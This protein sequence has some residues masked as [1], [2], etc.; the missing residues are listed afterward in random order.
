MWESHCLQDSCVK[1]SVRQSSD[2][3]KE[4]YGPRTGF[5][6]QMIWPSSNVQ[7]PNFHHIQM[8]PTA[9]KEVPTKKENL[10][11]FYDCGEVKVS[12]YLGKRFCLQR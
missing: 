11:E 6:K 5:P 2:A 4:L 12:L 3:K 1:D 9:F 7:D 8:M 10:E